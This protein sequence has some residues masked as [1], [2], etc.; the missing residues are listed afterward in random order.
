MPDLPKLNVDHPA[1]RDH[2][3]RSVGYWLEAGFDGLRLDHADGPSYDFWTDVRSVARSI[4]PDAWMFGELVRPPDQQLGY[5]GLFDG[6]LDFLLCQAM[7]DT[8]ATGSMSLAGSKP[9]PEPPR[10]VFSGAV[11]LQP[12]QLSG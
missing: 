7:R 3:L 1:V 9:L 11:R 4:K 6:T 12:P 2:L 5:A 8:F 10:N